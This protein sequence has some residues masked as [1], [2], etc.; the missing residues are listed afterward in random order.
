MIK[1]RKHDHIGLA[2]NN[3]DATVN[4]YIDVL[5]FELLGDFVGPDGSPCKFIRNTDITYEIYQP[6][7]GVEAEVEGK[8]DH[9]AYQSKDIEKDYQFCIEQGY[10]II[11]NGIEE[12]PTFWNDGCKYFKIASPSGEAIEFCEVIQKSELFCVLPDYVS[13]PDGMAVHESGDLVLACPNFAIDGMPGCILRITKDRQIRKWFDVPVLEET[14]LARPMGIEFGPDGDLYIVDNQGWS[15]KPEH[16]RKGRILRVRM[17]GD[18][19]VYCKTVAYH[20]EHPNGIRIWN[21]KLYVTNS[22]QELIKDTSGKLVSCIN[23]FGLEEENV[24]MTNTKE[25]AAHVLEYFITENPEDQYGLDGIAI[26]KEGVLYVGNFGDGTIWKVYLNLDGSMRSKELF[27]KDSKHLKVTDGMTF[28]DKGNL[29]IADFSVNAVGKVTPDG[30]VERM[31]QSPDSDGLHGELDQ[32]GEPC[33]WNG[34]LIVSC[35]DT[36]V[37]P[38]K[39]NT[40]HEQPATLAMLRL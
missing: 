38:G 5:G 6:V 15:G 33:F 2:T 27:V 19:M 23:Y 1:N 13:T 4:W 14:G 39:F 40:K 8:I 22:L 28:D 24:A 26:D 10:K 30:K 7:N 31:A 37:G 16:I 25:D 21:D 36:V 20:M 18:T 35:F 34:N 17:D 9:F 29:Y 32:P 3:I 11:T 12:I